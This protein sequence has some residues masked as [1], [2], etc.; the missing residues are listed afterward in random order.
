MADDQD[1]D[2]TE[3]P[4]PGRRREAREEGNVA[5]SSDLSSAALLVAVLVLLRATG[6]D[7]WDRMTRIGRRLFAEELGRVSNVDLMRIGLETIRDVATG[8]LP[9]MV[10]IVA[11]GV[12]AN[13]AQVGLLLSPKKLQ[14]NLKVLDPVGGFK[15]LFFSSKTYVGFAMN[16]AKLLLVA[17]VAGWAVTTEMAAI[18]ALPDAPAAELLAAGGRSVFAVGI[19]VAVTL[20]LLAFL[21]LAY[22]R[23]KHEQDLK[24]TKQQVKDEMKKMEG[25]PHVKQRRRQIALQRAGR[26]IDADVPTA[27]V[28]VTNPTHYAVAIKYDGGRMNA[29][30]VVAKGADL[31]AARIREVAATARVPIVERPPLA[32]A[33][34]RAVDVG[35]EIPEDLYA[36]VAE[37]LAYV[38]RLDRELSGSA[39]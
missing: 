7:L 36:A 9:L 21:D 25:D 10:G 14:P 5:K 3:D 33:L 20:L 23:W 24:M 22:Q 1:Q 15:K 37:I 31:V 2:K 8:V 13:V 19:K 18:L 17:A 30:R 27:D 32:R 35:R 12:L 28:V 38:Y 39:A 34:F 26:R 6:P 11:V 29:P 16:L 4:T